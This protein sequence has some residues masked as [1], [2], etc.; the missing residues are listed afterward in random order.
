[1][2]KQLLKR[3]LSGTKLKEASSLIIR[4]ID[5]YQD[6][7]IHILCVLMIRQKDDYWPKSFIPMVTQCCYSPLPE[8]LLEVMESLV[9]KY[10]KL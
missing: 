9:I 5:Q 8:T 7:T 1:M 2:Y 10:I 4:L 6:A 3:A